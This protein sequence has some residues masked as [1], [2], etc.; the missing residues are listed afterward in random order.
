MTYEE[1]SKLAD[2]ES[3]DIQNVI[4]S[5]RINAND[6]WNEQHRD[7]RRSKEWQA[8]FL[9]SLECLVCHEDQKTQKFFI[10]N[11]LRF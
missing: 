10:Q 9:A 1:W 6:T 7:D 11:G 2:T 4:D 8:M 5:A 3:A